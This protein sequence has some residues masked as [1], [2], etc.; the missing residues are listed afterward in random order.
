MITAEVRRAVWAAARDAAAAGELPALGNTDLST[1][2]PVPAERGGRPG[3]YAS[4][5]PYLLATGATPP[6]QIA[7]VLGRRLAG[8]D[9][10]AEAAAAAGHL[11]IT[12]TD[13]ALATLAVRVPQAA[14]LRA[15]ATSCAA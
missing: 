15:P 12:V 8:L 14:R 7:A 9:W 11:T 10:I 13:E 3:R 5:L 4:T 1:L 2:R 6:G